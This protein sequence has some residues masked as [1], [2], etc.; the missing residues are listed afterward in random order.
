MDMDP[1]VFPSIANPVY[2]LT[3]EWEDVSLT[4][5][6]EDGSTISRPRFTRSRGKWTL[7]WNALAEPEY[8]QLISF[9]KD[10]AQGKS[11]VFQWTHPVSGTVYTVRFDDKQPFKNIAPGWWAGEVSL[12][13]A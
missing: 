10:T 12:R 1:I 11:Q 2:P 9:W 13:E 4:S 6:F 5:G 3:E 8:Q 7:T